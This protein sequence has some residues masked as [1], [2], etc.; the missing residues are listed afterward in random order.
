MTRMSSSA[1]RLS[2]GF[3]ARA[4]A[5]AIL[6]AALAGFASAQQLSL[7]P[8]SLAFAS[9]AG[10]TTSQTQAVNV[11]SSGTNIFWYAQ[12]PGDRPAWLTNI[13]ANGVTTTTPLNVTVNPTGLAV[14]NYSTTVQVYSPYSTNAPTSATPLID[15]R[16]PG[17]GRGG[18][19]QCRQVHAGLHGHH[20]GSES[21]LADGSDLHH[22]HVEHH[23]DDFD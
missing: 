20:R 9:A 17:C 1:F 15:D 3:A 23:C 10:S 5:I 12:L 13:T 14:G 19:D 11:L 6:I 7:N 4:A 22:Q 21:G 18:N 16:H 2:A 8:T